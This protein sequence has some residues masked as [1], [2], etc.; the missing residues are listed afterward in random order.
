MV[1]GWTRAYGGIRGMA[2]P[3]SLVGLEAYERAAPPGGDAGRTRVHR[4]GSKALQLRQLLR[5]VR[6]D[7]PHSVTFL[8]V[9]L[10]DSVALAQH[11]D[12]EV[13]GPSVQT[14]R[15]PSEG[16]GDRKPSDRCR[17]PG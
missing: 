10:T 9:K 12:L 14:E 7:R 15:R 6:D 8:P 16:C 13:G 4:R 5:Q 3:Q 17:Q 2:E 1:G 11:A